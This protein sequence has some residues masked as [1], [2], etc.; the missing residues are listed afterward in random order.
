MFRHPHYLED[1][2]IVEEII[3]CGNDKEALCSSSEDVLKV[4]Q[5]SGESDHINSE[6]LDHI[7][8][9]KSDHI[10]SEK[11]D[12]IN[13]E[14]TTTDCWLEKQIGLTCRKA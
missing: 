7:N 8:S 14:G 5:V 11:S 13:S 2:Q 3:E 4:V 9:E 1:C 12:H 10:N 6:K